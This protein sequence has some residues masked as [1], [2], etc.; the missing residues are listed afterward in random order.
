M[1]SHGEPESPDDFE[2]RAEVE[3]PKASPVATS[4]HEDY[5]FVTETV[6]IVTSH[7]ESESPDDLD[8][9]AEVESPKESPV[10]S[11]AHEDYSVVSETVTTM[12]SHGEPESLKESPDSDSQKT[13][14]GEKLFGFASKAAKV[15]AGVVAA[16][17]ALTA[18]GA[19]AAYDAVTKDRSS[20]PGTVDADTS[21]ESKPYK[22]PISAIPAHEEYPLVTEIV[23]TTTRYDELQS[24]DEFERKAGVESPKESPVPTTAHEEYPIVTETVTTTT[25]YEEHERPDEFER[26]A[27][28]ESPKETPLPTTAHEEYPIVTE[29]VTTTTRHDELQSPDEFERKARLTSR[30]EG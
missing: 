18:M 15:A 21:G 16:P 4:A 22:E 24:P 7:G 3:S 8:R 2:R 19:V 11:P 26:K 1:T 6:T 5:P 20:E 12:T 29:T 14:F 10:A 9:R 30:K 25:R 23:T 17:V 13:A 27:E 28:V